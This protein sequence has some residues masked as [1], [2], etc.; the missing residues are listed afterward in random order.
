MLLALVLSGFSKVLTLYADD[1]LLQC[2]ITC[3]QDLWDHLHFVGILFDILDTTGLSMNLTK[4]V[5][6][7]QIAGKKFKKLQSRVL[8]EQAHQWFLLVPRSNGMATKI[9]LVADLK[10]LGC[11]LSYGNFEKLTLEH[12]VAAG[13]R[14]LHRWLYGKKGLDKIQRRKLWESVVRTTMTYGIWAT[15]VTTA[16][17]KRLVSLLVTMQRMIYMNHSHRTRDSHTFFFQQNTIE[18]PLQF[19]HR[20]CLRILTGHT[21]KLE[22]RPQT[23]VLHQFQLTGTRSMLEQIVQL[24]TGG[25]DLTVASAAFECR[26]CGVAFSSIQVLAHERSTHGVKHKRIQVFSAVRD[27]VDGK[28]I[29][30]HCHHSFPCWSALRTHTEHASCPLFDPLQVM[31]A[32]LANTRASLQPQILEVDPTGLSLNPCIGDYLR[33]HCILC[34]TQLLRFQDMTQ[35]LALEHSSLATQ[36][37]GLYQHWQG[38]MLSPCTFCHV[39]FAHT[40]HCKVLFQLMVLRAES[41]ACTGAPE[42]M[43][44]TP[45]SN[46]TPQPCTPNDGMVP[47]QVEDNGTKSDGPS[48]SPALDG[49]MHGHQITNTMGASLATSTSCT[50]ATASKHQSIADHPT[51]SRTPYEDPSSYVCIICAS[52]FAPQ[53]DLAEHMKIHDTYHS[54]RDAVMG[55]PTCTHCR[56]SFRETW[57]LQRHIVRKSCP[58]FDPQL[59]PT[60]ELCFDPDLQAALREGKVVEMLLNPLNPEERLRF[61]FSCTMCGMGHSR[62]ADLTRQ[63][64][65]QHGPFYRSADAYVLLL[66]EHQP[67]CVCAIPDAHHSQD[68][69]GAL[70]EVAMIE[71]YFNP[72]HWSFYTPW[73]IET[74]S[75]QRAAQINV[76][77]HAQAP[78]LLRRLADPQPALL[79]MDHASC[80]SL[81]HHCSLCNRSCSGASDLMHHIEHQHA[82]ECQCSQAL[83]QGLVTHFLAHSVPLPCK[84]CGVDQP[85]YNLVDQ[86]AWLALK[87]KCVVLQNLTFLHLFTRPDYASHGGTKVGGLRRGQANPAAGDILK[88][89]RRRTDSGQAT[90][91]QEAQGGASRQEDCPSLLDDSSSRRLPPD[92]SGLPAMPDAG[93][94]GSPSRR[95]LELSS[96]PGPVHPVSRPWPTRHATADDPDSSR[97]ERTI[98]QHHASQG[99]TDEELAG[100]TDEALQRVLCEALGRGL[101]SSEH[102]DQGDFGGQHDPVPA[103]VPPAGSACCLLRRQGWHCRTWSSDCNACTQLYRNQA[104]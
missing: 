3:K 74:D 33:S 96:L 11:K 14:R 37:S 35:H 22:L 90:V 7:F 41:L 85:T 76:R 62:V 6:L 50:G 2:E 15:G 86:S 31:S 66:E 67:D 5:V 102:P 69:T 23:D 34:G 72:N 52:S 38:S 59:Q 39:D 77:L 70:R 32:S 104:T 97:L 82:A 12:R 27:A 20:C 51:G 54:V 16:G 45:P 63:L 17:L 40:H 57:E 55:H 56:S 48:P 43:P 68:L 25:P 89:A 44:G 75:L 26:T 60:G 100:G 64:Q 65:T 9:K 94:P 19:L 91:S 47:F 101:P 13:F 36:A 95:C 93:C 99:S 30:R 24:I 92:D 29:C 81:R 28:S 10:Y 4:T 42:R 103:M 73:G 18:H 53:N 80:E 98:Q 61:T 21:A 88:Y 84:V 58:V 87:H 1:F 46:E 79:L 8:V 49:H 78:H 71:A 83:L